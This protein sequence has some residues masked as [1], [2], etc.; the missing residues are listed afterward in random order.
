MMLRSA[1]APMKRSDAV[2][3][4]VA[5][6][7]W[8]LSLLAAVF[9]GV[10][11]GTSVL[12]SC[13]PSGSNTTIQPPMELARGVTRRCSPAKS[14][15]S[16]SLENAMARRLAFQ[17]SSSRLTASDSAEE[18]FSRPSSTERCCSQVPHSITAMLNTT[19]GTM[20]RTMSTTSSVRRPRPRIRRKSAIGRAA[21]RPRKESGIRLPIS[22]PNSAIS[23]PIGTLLALF[24]ASRGDHKP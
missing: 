6:T 4:W 23:V 13:L 14:S 24:A 5:T 18:V 10:P 1:L 21:R 12:I 22:R 3:S 20:A 2:D 8:I 7:C 19:R 15:A 9:S 16:S 11:Y 17:L